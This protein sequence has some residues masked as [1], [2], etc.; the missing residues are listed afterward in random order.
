MATTYA[1]NLRVAKQGFRDNQ[2]TWG[3]VLN[4]NSLQMLIEAITDVQEVDVGS[5][6]ATLTTNNGTTDQA[7]AA[8]LKVT[9]SPGTTRTV[10]APAATKFYVIW[11][12]VG[13]SS[14]VQI[15]TAAGTAATVKAGEKIM[16]FCDGTDFYRVGLGGATAETISGNWAFSN[17]DINGGTINGITDLAVADGGTGAS[18]AADARTN[19]G[20]VIGTNVQAFDS[21]LSAIA[22][23]A[24]T[25]GNFIVGNGSA[26]VAESGATARASLGLTIGTNVQAYDA[27]LAAIAGLTS[28]ADRLPYFTGSGTAS[29]A[30]FTAAG[31]ALVD[32]ANAA[33][34]LI[35]LGLTATAAELNVLDGITASVTELNYTDGVTSAIQTQLDAKQ[36]SDTGLTEIAAL[37]V[38]D[39]NFIV[40]N[41]TSWVAESG[42]TARTSLG[43]GSLATLSSINNS[44]WSGTDLSVANGGT[45]VSTLTGIVKGS[46]TSAFSAATAGTDYYAPGST[47]V[48]VADGGTGAS[49][50][51]AALNNLLPSQSGN[52]GKFL[53]TNGTTHSWAA[54]GAGDFLADGSVPMTGN[55]TISKA[56]P[57]I[58]LTDSGGSD[59][60]MRAQSS[61]FIIQDV[62]GADDILTLT[63]AGALT[64]DGDQIYANSDGRLKSLFMDFDSGAIID[65]LV[66]GSYWWNREACEQ[67][68]YRGY[69]E[70]LH[71]GVDSRSVYALMGDAAA[72]V[73]PFD[74]D[75]DGNSKSGQWFRTIKDRE[76]LGLALMELKK[77]RRRIRELE[78]R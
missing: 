35:T 47:D 64:T 41:G 43:L 32:D 2:N 63:Q 23:L 46:G 40:G 49:T 6:N 38:T 19:L 30:T 13:D 42:S 9:G 72:P 7:R 57:L 67:A 29:L 70:L 71:F 53:T 14:D 15:K 44:N 5:G 52:S 50:A 55:L 45:G 8:G 20:L 77:M 31:R 21:D 73:S 68:G 22:A 39:G 17:I 78:V 59:F 11:N 37:A 61:S 75:K 58:G 24:K 34:Q 74:R 48:A 26:W 27:E 65:E 36:A 4:D 66:V 51:A 69:D 76:M 18:S 25:D 10:T 28:A 62:T 33:A 54:G 60:S 12:A 3:T 16:V 56:T 1:N